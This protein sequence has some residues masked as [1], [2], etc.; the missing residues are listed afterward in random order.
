MMSNNF[1]VVNLTWHDIIIIDGA[2]KT[3]IPASQWLRLE[4]EQS[5][6]LIWTQNGIPL[7]EYSSKVNEYLLSCVA[8]TKKWVI[9]IVS[10][11]VAQFIKRD[12]FFI[13]ANP[14][15]TKEWKTIWCK[16]IAKN[17]YLNI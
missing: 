16:W 8:P 17:P 3:T 12:D 9:Y 13:I 11:V 15:K 4:L 10:I 2:N 5:S 1:D 14:I 7:Y 6:E